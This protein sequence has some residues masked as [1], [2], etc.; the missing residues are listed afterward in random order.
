MN[1]VLYFVSVKNGTYILLTNDEDL[2]VEED[3]SY[4]L[5]CLNRQPTAQEN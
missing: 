2:T 3:V 4:V 1:N 5:G